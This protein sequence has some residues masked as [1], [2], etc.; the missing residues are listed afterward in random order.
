[1]AV[2]PWLANYPFSDPIFQNFETQQYDQV[3]GVNPAQTYD[4]KDPVAEERAALEKEL[5]DLKKAEGASDAD[6]AKA[7]AEVEKSED[8]VAS[9]KDAVARVK[10][11]QTEK[12]AK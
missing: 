11:R 1:M 2:T 3:S 8:P 4:V 5:T 6:V 7:L 9:L 12:G 10:A